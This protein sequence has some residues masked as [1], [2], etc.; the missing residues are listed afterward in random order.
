MA[1]E[2]FRICWRHCNFTYTE[3]KGA[4]GGLAIL[5]NPATIILEPA[6]S[7]V[8]TLTTKYRL[9]WS[10]KAGVITNSYNPRLNQEKDHFID[11]LAYINTLQVQ[12][13]WILG[14]DFNIILTLE[15]KSG[16]LKCLE[17]DSNKFCHLIDSL[18]LIDI[19]T[20][21]GPY[22]CTNK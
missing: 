11:S 4:T 13:R 12:D 19:E 21:N 16:G 7:T 6:Y 3:S 20:R 17:Q 1:E 5:W 8:G 14:G 15:E 18:N 2:T 10:S 22:T 9:I